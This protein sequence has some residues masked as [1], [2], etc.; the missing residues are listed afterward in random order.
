MTPAP[1]PPPPFPLFLSATPTAH[2]AIPIIFRGKDVEGEE[3]RGERGRASAG[4]VITTQCY[5]TVGEGKK[6]LCLCLQQQ[7]VR[8][9]RLCRYCAPAYQIIECHFRE[10]SKQRASLN[11]HKLNET[12]SLG[13]KV[14]QG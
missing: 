8:K 14:S 4:P 1:I 13:I 5:E 6:S 7:R 3:E 9:Q 11:L 10:G 2:S 12:V